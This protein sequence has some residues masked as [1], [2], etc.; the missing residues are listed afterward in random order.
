MCDIKIK[1]GKN[2]K[3]FRKQRKLSQEKLAELLDLSVISISNMENG[4][5]LTSF[6][7]LEQMSIILGVNIYEFFLFNKEV[8]E[9]ILYK[10][11]IENI[12]K[13]SIRQDSEKLMILF[14]VSENLLNGD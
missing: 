2:I 14:Q 4:K 5:F 9:E 12:K 3:K 8:K 7:T 10:K 1:I 6:K 11:L 13:T